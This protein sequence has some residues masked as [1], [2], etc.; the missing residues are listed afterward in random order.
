LSTVSQRSRNPPADD[1]ES[2]L[3]GKRPVFAVVYRLGLFLIGAI[4][5]DGRGKCVEVCWAF[6]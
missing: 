3:L 2:D 6:A 5:D 1:T 4:R